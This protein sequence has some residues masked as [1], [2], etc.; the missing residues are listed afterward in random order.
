ML[1]TQLNA[2]TAVLTGWLHYRR[3]CAN[4]TEPLMK[5]L[6]LLGIIIGA[7]FLTAAPVS[8]Q[9][10]PKSVVEISVN[11]A[12]ALVYRRHYRRAYRRSYYGYG[13]GGAYYGASYPRLF[14]YGLHTLSLRR[15]S[16][17]WWGVL[18]WVAVT[19]TC[20]Q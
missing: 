6:S 3:E 19:P 17:P 13:Y 14:G 18:E 15:V 2:A 8:I 10:S 11:K 20:T 4:Q 1:R 5:K 7:A 9:P 12:D 16:P